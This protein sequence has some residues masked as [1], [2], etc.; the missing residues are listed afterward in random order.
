MLVAAVAGVLPSATEEWILLRLPYE[1]ALTYEVTYY[2]TKGVR[3]KSGH[4]TSHAVEL[5]IAANQ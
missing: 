5:M 2:T 3:F 4:G 1:R